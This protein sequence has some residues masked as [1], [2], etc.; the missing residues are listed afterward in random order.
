M[1]V[2][3]GKGSRCTCVPKTAVFGRVY[4]G[5]GG[6][7]GNLCSFLGFKIARFFLSLKDVLQKMQFICTVKKVASL[8]PWRQ[9]AKWQKT[10]TDSTVIEPT[11]I[12]IPIFLHIPRAHEQGQICIWGFIGK[13][14]NGSKF[15]R[16]QNPTGAA[17]KTEKNL[18]KCSYPLCK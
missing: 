9:N 18:F 3:Q 12:R 1:T 4:N 8:N 14:C 6:F 11:Y 7:H 13:S 17:K 10:L 2:T 16:F 5:I 15:L